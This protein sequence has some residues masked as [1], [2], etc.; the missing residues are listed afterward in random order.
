MILSISY[1]FFEKVILIRV[2]IVL[3]ICTARGYNRS[4]RSHRAFYHT[5]VSPKTPAFGVRVFDTSR[6]S[7]TNLI[8]TLL[9]CGLNKRW[10][11]TIISN[12]HYPRF[13]HHPPQSQSQLPLNYT[14]HTP[15]YQSHLQGQKCPRLNQFA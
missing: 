4:Q 11:F 3:S 8:L 6:I 2:S 13:R 1:S 5:S 12:W 9:N 14:I 7:K 10:H 15:V